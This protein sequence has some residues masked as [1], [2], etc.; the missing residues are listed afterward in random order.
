MAAHGGRAQI[1]AN[2]PKP[3]AMLGPPDLVNVFARSLRGALLRV[4]LQGATPIEPGF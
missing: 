3:S 4:D 1:G 2:V